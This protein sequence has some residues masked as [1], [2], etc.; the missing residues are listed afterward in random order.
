MVDTGQYPCGCVRIDKPVKCRHAVESFHGTKGGDATAMA[1]KCGFIYADRP[2]R[3]DFASAEVERAQERRP[4]RTTTE[5]SAR[6][7]NRPPGR[8]ACE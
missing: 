4:R 8:H 3:A 2:D 1:G 7:Q 5:P 6:L